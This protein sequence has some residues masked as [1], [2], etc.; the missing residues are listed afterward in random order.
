MIGKK[1]VDLTVWHRL[2]AKWKNKNSESA[3]ASTIF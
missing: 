1:K 3:F 2:A